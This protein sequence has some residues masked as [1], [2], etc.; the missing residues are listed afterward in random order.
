M[1]CRA[2]YGSSGELDVFGAT[3]YFDGLADL[4]ASP[5][6][7]RQPEPKDMMIQVKVMH[8]QKEESYRGTQELG[9]R[10]N[11]NLTA[12]HGS[13]LVSPAASFHK[14]P[15]AS[16]YDKPHH[17][18]S[19]LS[20]RGSSDVVTAVAAACGRD[21]GEVVGDRR[22]QGVQVV[23]RACDGEERWVVRCGGYPLEEQHH[24]SMM[25]M[26]N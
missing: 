10:T 16:I 2:R 18:A 22:L 23:R 24:A 26:R 12:F 17:Q 14:N 15:P 1:Q 5:V 3:R 4:A 20:S 19:S 21:L 9:A 13:S 8:H 7:A 11:S 6:T 25:L